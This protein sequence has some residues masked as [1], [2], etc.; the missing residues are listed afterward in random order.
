MVLITTV[1]ITTGY[2]LLV[3]VPS[4]APYYQWR[5]YR[6][7]H[8]LAPPAATMWLDNV[9]AFDLHFPLAP[10]LYVLWLSV[11]EREPLL[12][13][14]VLPVLQAG[15]VTTTLTAPVTW[16]WAQAGRILALQLPI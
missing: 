3:A 12:S 5:L 6:N 2:R 9:L 1:R 13:G 8:L 11:D 7:G 10:G 4:S 14:P 16:G 15:L